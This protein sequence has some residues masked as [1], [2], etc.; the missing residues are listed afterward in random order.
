M[1]IDI[2]LSAFSFLPGADFPLLLL[3][4]LPAAFSKDDNVFLFCGKG[5]IP[6][7]ALANALFNSEAFSVFDLSNAGAAK[8]LRLLFL[9]GLCEHYVSSLISVRDFSLV[10]LAVISRGFLALSLYLVLAFFSRTYWND[11]CGCAVDYEL[12][13]SG[14]NCA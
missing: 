13:F 1:L 14:L 6:F 4:V 10:C 11:I 2:F 5:V 12:T 3:V 8:F 9:M 7:P